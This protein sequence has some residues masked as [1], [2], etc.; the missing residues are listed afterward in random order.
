MEISK[1]QTYIYTG[2][3]IE[4]IFT[5]IQPFFFRNIET[6]NFY[7]ILSNYNSFQSLSNHAFKNACFLIII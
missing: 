7:Y 3:L 1:N 2:H 6:Y 5:N 4:K